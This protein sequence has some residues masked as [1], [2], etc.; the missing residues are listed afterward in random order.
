M[1]YLLVLSTASS[2][3]EAAKLADLLLSHKLAACVNLVPNVESHYRWKGRKEKSREVLMLIKTRA[4]AYKKL[5]ALIHKHHSY[6]VPEIIAVP[7]QKGSQP[8]LNW[9]QSQ[10]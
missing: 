6:E 2:K 7:I 1:S 4:S 10:F 5:E 8:Y 3:K 9:I